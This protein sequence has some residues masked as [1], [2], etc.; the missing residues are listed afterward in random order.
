MNICQDKE[1]YIINKIINRS[2]KYKQNFIII[3]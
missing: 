1:L 2:N 3:N